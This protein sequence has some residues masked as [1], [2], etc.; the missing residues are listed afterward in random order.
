MSHDGCFRQSNIKFPDLRIL[1]NVQ[2]SGPLWYMFPFHFLSV[3]SAK[4]TAAQRTQ[5]IQRRFEPL[6]LNSCI[7]EEGADYAFRNEE[8]Q[9]QISQK[10]KALAVGL[11][12]VIWIYNWIYDLIQMH[13]VSHLPIIIFVSLHALHIVYHLLS[14][15][16]LFHLLWWT[17]EVSNFISV[18]CSDELLFLYQPPHA[19]NA[20]VQR[21]N[22]ILLDY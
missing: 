21:N 8:S 12:T 15:D 5:H 6:A 22:P 7:L 9:K 13:K 4:T 17:A 2:Y 11:T 16:S 3:K 1:Q 20:A 14:W 19:D 10:W 18:P